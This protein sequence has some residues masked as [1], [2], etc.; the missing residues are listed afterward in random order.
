MSP[1]PLHPPVRRAVQ[2]GASLRLT[3][4]ELWSTHVAIGL[5]VVTTIGWLIMAFAMSLDVVEGSVAALRIFGFESEPAQAVRD[6]VTGEWT[7]RALSLGQFVIGIQQFIGG[8]AYMLGTLLALFAAAPLSAAFIEPGRIDLLLSKPLPRLRLLAG[9]VAGVWGVMAVLALYLVGAV[10][11]VLGVK[12]G[13]WDPAFLWALPLITVMFAVMYG[14]VLLV[15]VTTRS[16]ALA[17]IVSYGL[18]FFSV[19]FAAHEQIEPQLAGA[20]REA[21]R[22]LYHVLPNFAEVIGVLGQLIEDHAVDSLYP[23]NS[24]LLFGAA[25]YV[26]AAVRFIRRD[27]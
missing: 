3:A 22:A 7:R 6:P 17:L 16:A 10:W 20:T 15:V 5:F 12:T 25:C 9:H 21:F 24:S 1:E 13:L 18:I 27:F 19:F 8:A 2:F 23:L 4:R 11:I 14:V 26:V